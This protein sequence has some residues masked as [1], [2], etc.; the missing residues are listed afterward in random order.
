MKRLLIVFLFQFFAFNIIAITVKLQVDSRVVYQG[1]PFNA[2]V[3]VSGLEEVSGSFSLK[4]TRSFS[5]QRAGISRNYSVNISN[6]K[7]SR[8]F[9][10]GESFSLTTKRTGGFSIGPGIFRYKGKNY[11]TSKVHIKVKKQSVYRNLMKRRQRG[12]FSDFFDPYQRREQVEPLKYFG[13]YSLDKKSCF[14]N[15]EIIL[16]LD[17]YVNIDRVRLLKTANRTLVGFWEDKIGEG[18]IEGPIEVKKNGETW[19]RYRKVL[20]HLFPTS[21]GKKIIPPVKAIF[22]IGMRRRYLK[23]KPITLWVKKIPPTTLENFR[24][25][26]GDYSILL[27]LLHNKFIKNQPFEVDVFVL[28][29]GNIGSISDPLVNIFSNDFRVLSPRGTVNINHDKSTV[30]PD[31]IKRFRYTIY[32]LKKGS[33]NLP[34]FK[35][36]FFN[37]EKK[38]YLEIKTDK[39]TIEVLPELSSGVSLDN[40]LKHESI[41][42]K[43][44]YEVSVGDVNLRPLLVSVTLLVII[45]FILVVLLLF[46]MLSYRRKLILSDSPALLLK[47]KAYGEGR[48]ALSQAGKKIKTA[49]FYEA[50]GFIEKGLK[51][52]LLRK[53]GQEGD[54]VV[55][56]ALKS[57]LQ[58]HNISSELVVQ[59]SHL[60]EECSSLRYGMGAREKAVKSLLV[61]SQKMIKK[62][63]QLWK[64]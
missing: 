12:F 14:V 55:I 54:N 24:G 6:G 21:P 42:D 43:I 2:T 59:L 45:Y 30:G 44:I 40:D 53:L 46:L 41:K 48:R 22:A 3:V 23:M 31:A 7:M 39:T 58:R 19:Y 63:E 52:Y 10:F 47:S 8:V 27:K 56:S 33:L 49:D 36:V 1:V 60:I 25:D 13:E 26:V 64:G 4:T 28:G 38:K 15:Q 57:D 37:P 5:V 20:A 61:N 35:L 50:L 11:Y 51:K 17:L 34:V 29:K 18:D 32:P 9:V 62:M 16:N